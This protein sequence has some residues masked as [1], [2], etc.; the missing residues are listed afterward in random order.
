MITNVKVEL[1]DKERADIARYLGY[2]GLLTRKQVNQLVAQLFDHLMLQPGR[3]RDA[4]QLHAPVDPGPAVQQ[5]ARTAETRVAPA[6]PNN[7]SYMRGWRAVGQA[8]RRFK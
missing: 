7:A 6:E 2:P 1:T 5:A 3:V 4:D 8:I